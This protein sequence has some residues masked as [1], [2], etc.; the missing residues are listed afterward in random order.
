MIAD[1]LVAR[2]DAR[3]R[4]ELLD[5]LDAPGAH[6]GRDHR[7]TGPASLT[8]V[9]AGD[10]KPRMPELG[11]DRQARHR[12]DAPP[13][14]VEVLPPRPARGGRLPARQILV[15]VEGVRVALI[16]ISE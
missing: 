8:N 2:T 14:V 16:P 11:C 12:I 7:G 10:F 3:E 13:F 9:L 6:G 1:P 4:W 5:V 15:P